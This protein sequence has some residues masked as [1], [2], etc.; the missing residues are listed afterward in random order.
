MQLTRKS[1]TTALAIFGL[2]SL[3]ALAGLAWFIELWRAQDYLQSHVELQAKELD[4]ELAQLSILPRLLS[5]DP[6]IAQA[7]TANDRTT[8]RIANETLATTKTQS[9]VSFAFLMNTV[10][11]TIASS[12]WRDPVSFVGRNYKFRPY[13]SEALQGR[14]ST[15]FAVGATTG[16][17][18]YFVAEAVRKD[19]TVIGVIVVKIELDQ[20]LESWSEN[21]FTSLIVDE[22]GVVILSTES[23]LLYAPTK[24]LGTEVLQKITADRRYILNTDSELKPVRRSLLGEH[25]WQI[26]HH[27]QATFYTSI[28]SKLSSENWTLLNFLSLAVVAKGA[29]L[30]FSI[31]AALLAIAWLVVRSYH[32]R[33]LIARTRDRHATLLESKVKQRTDELQSAQQALIA[34]SNFAMLGRMSAAINHE[35]NQPL[36]SLRFNLATLRQLMDQ[37]DPASSDL[38]ETIIASDRTTKRI[39][40]VVETLRSVARQGNND[41]H[42]INVSQLVVDVANIVQRERKIAATALQI[43]N[44]TATGG[45]TIRGN[46]ILLQQALLNLLYNAMDAVLDVNNPRVQIYA[47]LPD[48]GISADETE[49][50]AN[51]ETGLV[52]ASNRVIIGIEDN[53]GGINPSLVEHLFHPFRSE[54]SHRKGLGLGLTLAK[55]IIED[56]NGTLNYAPVSTGGSHFS[57]HLPIHVE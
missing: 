50:T 6:R 45:P 19:E 18:G 5:L 39:G 31:L 21:S 38:R 44:I 40:R 9:G 53:G 7:L 12:N 24:I 46:E 32:Q 20:L 43:S 17:P 56:H 33:K 16:V 10:G 25:F 1:K 14:S 8:I 52:Q 11:D 29:I 37:P 30:Y 28:D 42:Q 35:I 48:S 47:A 27:D 51:P 2:A 15:F 34:Q 4:R 23:R 26:Y 36:A 41:L 57:V 55:Q 13:F 3:V 49:N 54:L 22:L